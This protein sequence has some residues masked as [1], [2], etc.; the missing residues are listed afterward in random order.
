M[1]VIGLA[2]SGSGDDDAGSHSPGAF[3]RRLGDAYRASG[4]ALES[5]FQ[6]TVDEARAVSYTGRAGRA[7]SR[8]GSA[9]SQGVR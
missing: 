1:R 8:E 3:I 7:Q 5:G 4:R 2:L 6:T 9:A